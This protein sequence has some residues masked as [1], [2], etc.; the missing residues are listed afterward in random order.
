M[1]N[2]AYINGRWFPLS[3][4]KVSV[5]DRGFQFGDGVYEVIR[6]YQGLPFQVGA[7][8][9]R[10]KQ[11]AEAIGLDFV[12]SKKE[13]IALFTKIIKKARF[14]EVKIYVQLTRGPA[15]RNHPF[16]LRARTTVVVTARP[17][18]P[19]PTRWVEEGVSVITLPDIRWGRCDIKSINLLP[20]ILARQE[21]AVRG[22]HEAIFIRDGRVMEGSSSNVFI[23]KGGRIKTPPLGNHALPGV[24]RDLVIRLARDAGIPTRET[25]IKL[26]ELILADEV[27]LTG[28]T[29]DILPVVKV[30]HRVIGRRR[31]G[32][33]TRDLAQGFRRITRS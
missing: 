26:R 4:A 1:P 18:G 19:V 28:T 20:N 14:P 7:H 8:L 32:S 24:T 27:F 16:P 6:T 25:E 17:I 11:S 22:V 9:A 15:P 13:W 5:E 30:D 12:Y 31:V 10:L 2:I 33:I 23:V 21:A 29:V 3:R